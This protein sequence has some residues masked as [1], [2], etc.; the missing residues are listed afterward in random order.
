MYTL[1]PFTSE[2]RDTWTRS[3]TFRVKAH[4]SRTAGS[5]VAATVTH[6]YTG[7]QPPLSSSYDCPLLSKLSLPA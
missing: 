1:H 5:A 3:E 7:E 4:K 6:F 2:I